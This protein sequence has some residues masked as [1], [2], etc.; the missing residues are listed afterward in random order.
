MADLEAAEHAPLI[1]STT[2]FSYST[3]RT[4]RKAKGQQ[5]RARA[6]FIVFAMLAVAI[7]LVFLQA[8]RVDG[9]EHR[10]HPAIPGFAPHVFMNLAMYAPY[11]PS[12]RYEHPPKGCHVTQV[13]IVSPIRDIICLVAHANADPTPWR[14]ISYRFGS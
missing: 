7:A 5:N 4:G 1:I 10:I 14:S 13:N 6:C 12:G 3:I 8:A 9:L 2:H 11:F